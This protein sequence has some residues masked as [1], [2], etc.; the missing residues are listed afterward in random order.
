MRLCLC[1]LQYARL[2]CDSGAYAR[3]LNADSKYTTSW[4]VSYCHSSRRQRQSTRLSATENSADA[5][6]CI[7]T[8]LALRK[9][10]SVASTSS[11]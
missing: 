3:Q 1:V 11:R 10:L 2:S 9:R 6:K 5:S 8:R 4:L 7:A